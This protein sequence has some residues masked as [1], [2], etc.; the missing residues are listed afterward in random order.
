MF[1]H[2]TT[3]ARGGCQKCCISLCSKVYI[4]HFYQMKASPGCLDILIY[5]SS[6]HS[7]EK[8]YNDSLFRDW[9][10]NTAAHMECPGLLLVF[11]N[12][13]SY[14]DS[15][16]CNNQVLV[17]VLVF[18]SPVLSPALG[19]VPWWRHQMETFSALLALCVGNSPVTE[20]FLSQRPVTRS[21]DVFFDLRLNKRFSKQSWGWWFETAL[22]SLWRHCNGISGFVRL[23][24]CLK[25]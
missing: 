4:N 6:H 15:N 12:Q 9:K 18:V 21:F 2:S 17:L 14:S 19:L 1:P 7:Q 8:G 24:Y 16:S 22:C 13:Y 5:W 20:E 25:S 10:C 11:V 23:L 3:R